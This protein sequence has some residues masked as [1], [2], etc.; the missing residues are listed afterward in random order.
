V[1]GK[2]TA[3]IVKP[4]DVCAS[5]MRQPCAGVAACA[6]TP[7]KRTDKQTTPS[8]RATVLRF[9]LRSMIMPKEVGGRATQSRKCVSIPEQ[10]SGTSNMR[11]ETCPRDRPRRHVPFPSLDR[12]P[13][14]LNRITVEILRFERDLVRKP[15]STHWVK[16][17]GHAFRDH[18]L[19]NP[20]PAVRR[21]HAAA[22]VVVV[23]PIVKSGPD[24]GEEKAPVETPVAKVIVMEAGDVHEG[25]PSECMRSESTPGDNV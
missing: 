6:S 18:A 23:R 22:A 21:Q 2:P 15:V 4:I 13:I 16:A 20:T 7:H 5:S 10:A 24:A 19:A 17:R 25:V 1:V 8:R 14:Q 3:S 11:T 9:T 12:D